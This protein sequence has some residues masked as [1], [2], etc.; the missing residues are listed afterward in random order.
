MKINLA[1]NFCSKRKLHFRNILK[2]QSCPFQGQVSKT[3]DNFLLGDVLG[4]QGGGIFV[5]VVDKNIFLWN[6]WILLVS[7]LLSTHLK[8]LNGLPYAGF[9]KKPISDKGETW[10]LNVSRIPVANKRE[11]TLHNY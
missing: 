10:K 9:L 8:R 5:M 4:E 6:F 3:L 2:S 11:P 1:P 7:V